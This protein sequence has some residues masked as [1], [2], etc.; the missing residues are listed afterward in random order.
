M[1]T[2][3]LALKRFVADLGGGSAG[4]TVPRESL[5]DV[6]LV[7]LNDYAHE[8]LNEFE[9]ARFDREW[10][11]DNRFCDMFGP[12]HIQ[13]YHLNSF[14]S[15]F[16]VRKVVSTKAMLK[17]CGPLM[18]KLATWLFEQGHWSDEDMAYYRDL[19]GIKPGADLIA[20]DAF[21]SS[22]WSYVNSHPVDAP[23]DLDD[24]DYHDDHFTI[25][26][27]TAGK[28][29]VQPDCEPGTEIALTLPKTI[30]AMARTGWSVSLELGRLHGK[31]RI[32]GAGIV[33]P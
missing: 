24:V 23:D 4:I 16:I 12:D 28:L 26:K 15:T 2:I 10:D 20:C 25:A 19:V 27:V 17:A 18:E 33:G 21:A 3:T 7:Y 30:T 32:L 5:V 31:W 29:H 8:H 22:L 9:R 6:F 11:E 1:D 14:M 13:P